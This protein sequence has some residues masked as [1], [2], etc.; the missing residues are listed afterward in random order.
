M[1]IDTIPHKVYETI[2]TINCLQKRQQ[3]DWVTWQQVAK[4]QE[5][6]EALADELSAWACLQEYSHLFTQAQNNR[7][8]CLTP[9]GIQALQTC[10]P[11]QQSEMQKIAAIIK[12]YAGQ[13]RKLT[14]EV[15]SIDPIR[16]SQRRIV[17]A[18]RI[19]LSD[20]LVPNDALVAIVPTKGGA[21]VNGRVV[22]QDAN[23]GTLF[24]ALESRCRGDLLPARLE[25]DRAFLLNQLATSLGK[26]ETFPPLGRSLTEPDPEAI[27]PI[28]G[29][30]SAVVADSLASLKPP[31]TRFLWGPPGA[32]KTY[33]LARLML[34]LIESHPGERIL[35]V[36]PSNLAVDVAFLQFINQLKTHPRRQLL[37]ERRLLRFGYPRKTEILS[38]SQLLGSIENEAVNQMI[39]QKGKEVR[40]AATHEFPEEKQAVLRAELLDLQEQ[41]KKSVFDHVAKCQIVATTT[42]QAYSPHSP[43]TAQQWDTVLVDEVT[44]VPPAICLYLSSLAI[45]RFLLAGDPRQLGPIFEA[46]GDTAREVETWMGRDVFDFANLS[47]GVGEARQI[48]IDDYRLARITSQR[49]CTCDIWQPIA[50]LYKEVESNVDE[51]RLWPLRKVHPGNGRGIVLVDVG[52]ERD[53]ARCELIQKSWGNQA[54]AALAIEV[55]QQLTSQFEAGSTPSIA[56]ITPYRAQYRMI[57]QLLR[58]LELKQKV[59]VGTIHQFQGSEADIVIFDMV[60][61]PGRTKPGQLLT[62]DT[63]LRLVNVAISRARGKF[64]LLAHQQ[65]CRSAMTRAQNPLLWDVVMGKTAVPLLNEKVELARVHPEQPRV[66]ITEPKVEPSQPIAQTPLNRVQSGPV[67]LGID[68]SAA[69]IQAMKTGDVYSIPNKTIKKQLNTVLSQMGLASQY[70]V[71]SHISNWQGKGMCYRVDHGKKFVICEH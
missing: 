66:K 2:K 5:G 35:L 51:V 41:L 60:D 50:N 40:D 4:H 38:E 26:L 69:Q 65:W 28:R 18:V 59:E 20:A 45:K 33:G 10:P 6:S 15:E 14:F 36:S 11:P 21:W 25:V 37:A 67:V 22:G 43:I 7:G 39:A 23:T 44:M 19:E 9:E 68:V 34:R 53:E 8:V 29:E 64:I 17:H 58:E 48:R 30:D 42:A 55:V 1:T 49:R 24:L 47:R 71:S 27:F 46:R 12:K 52:R 62:G 13:L 3:K 63:G 61:G 54:T 32:G 31:W 57:K 70:D 56:I 16:N